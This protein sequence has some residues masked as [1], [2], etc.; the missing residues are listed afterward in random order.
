MN[1]FDEIVFKAVLRA[2]KNKDSINVFPNHVNYSEVMKVFEDAISDSLKRLVEAGKIE[3]VD[4]MH[5]KCYKT[6]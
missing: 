3:T 1:S 5:H 2:Q 6:K 4:T